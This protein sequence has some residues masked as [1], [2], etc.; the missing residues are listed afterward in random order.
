M[1]KKKK[2]I[3][4]KVGKAITNTAKDAGKAV[5]NTAKD[6]GKIVE[7]TAD[8]VAQG[9]ESAANT[10]AKTVVSISR[11]ALNET[12]KGF[13]AAIKESGKLL[14]EA[15]KAALKATTMD[16]IK[17]HNKEIKAL[18]KAVKAIATDPSLKNALHTVVNK[19]ASNKFDTEFSNALKSIMLGPSFVL[20]T[21]DVSSTTF[22]TISLGLSGGGGYVAGVEA[23]GGMGITHPGI[24]NGQVCGY[25]DAGGSLGTFGGAAS[26]TLGIET[27]RPEGIG[28]GYIGVTLE[29]E[30]EIG[31][32]LE[33]SFNVPDFTLGGITVSAGVG[34]ELAAG[35]N[36][37]YTYVAAKQNYTTPW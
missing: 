24:H 22:P 13:N 5:V 35:V 6:A 8:D 33:I 28:G 4:D 1:A 11:D 3:F 12:E 21:Q 32:G 29:A 2:S 7:N 14:D 23:S 27:S 19:A 31:V 26:V 18:A 36:G 20:L 15:R 37:G 34:M 9:A 16:I 17:K 25:V 10:V 30:V